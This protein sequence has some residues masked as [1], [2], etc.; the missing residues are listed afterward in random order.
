MPF[1][2]Y[3][4][5]LLGLATVPGLV[6]I[7]LLHR[8]FERREV[9]ALF[10]WSALARAEQGGRRLERFRMPLLFLVE[11]L[12]LV[13]LALA[14]T[15]LRY[16]AGRG[17]RPLVVVLD[18]SYSLRAVVGE[19][20]ARDRGLAALRKEVDRY[21]PTSV[22]VILAGADPQVAVAAAP[23]VLALDQVEQRWRCLAPA[24]NLVAAL[25]LAAEVGEPGA[26]VAVVTDHP[27]EEGMLVPGRRWLAVGLP[28]PNAAFI[29]ARRSP[30][31]GERDRCFLQVANPGRVPVRTSLTVTGDGQPLGLDRSL[32]LPP[33]GSE[34]VVFELPKAVDMVRAELA[35]DALAT[36]NQVLLLPP[37][38][39]RVRVVN[40]IA[41]ATLREQVDQALAASGL[42][43]PAAGVPELVISDR[44]PGPA[45]AQR[46]TLEIRVPKESLPFTGPFVADWGH[47][48]IQGLDFGGV[49]WAG[50]AGTEPEG[51]PVL[52][53][54]NTSLLE[55]L[56]AG[57]GH[58]LRMYLDVSRSTISRTPNW[59][60]LFW[61]LLDWRAEHHPG[62]VETEV[63]MGQ[64]ARLLLPPI[65][66]DVAA[67]AIRLEVP[68]GP[69]REL[70]GQASGECAVA[71]G[72]PG[73]YSARV[74][75]QTYR[76]ACNALSP[77]EGD[78]GDCRT[79]GLGADPTGGVLRRDYA[80]GAWVCGLLACGL[81]FLH[82]FLLRPRVRS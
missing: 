53:A 25:S 70:A 75:D 32:D 33:G 5:A 82:A 20:S 77:R 6:A 26:A 59:P 72:V 41:D 55:D 65:P 48:L 12:A 30:L 14:A 37:R 60:A 27:P 50:Q 35:A 56:E 78:L 57:G 58:A 39:H 63:R 47:R 3:P 54:G 76:F 9:T 38:P 17:A 79:A 1:L 15:D 43:D 51:Q 24:G 29:A 21:R 31:D 61:N 8:R 80:S 52:M 18:D 81:L 69:A 68:D 19:T 44:S 4:L 22:R 34:Q 13:A 16:L 49:V 7:Y 64:T 36:D 11:L 42:R 67:P 10:L 23:P 28:A 62:F 40:A 74:G 66:P 73:V 71:A 46:W 45:Q 2:A